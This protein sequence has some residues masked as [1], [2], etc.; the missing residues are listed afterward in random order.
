MSRLNSEIGKCWPLVILLA[1]TS[2]AGA[3]APNPSTRDLLQAEADACQAFEDG[4]AEALRRTLTE[5]FTLVDSR[6]TVTG[7][8]QNLAEVAAREPFYKEFRNHDQQVRLYG[9]AALI[10]GIT[11]IRGRADGKAFA[12]EFRYTDTWIRRDGKWLLAA[13]HASRLP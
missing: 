7:R 6:G 9:D 4:N 10:V 5:D 2:T 12:A 13:S 3:V 11:S 1:L 8:A